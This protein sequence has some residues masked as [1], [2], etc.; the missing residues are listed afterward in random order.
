MTYIGPVYDLGDGTR[1][2]DIDA[3][4]GTCG[5]RL[6]EVIHDPSA[7]WNAGATVC[8]DCG[9]AAPAYHASVTA[10]HVNIQPSKQAPGKCLAVCR[11]GRLSMITTREHAQQWADKHLQQAA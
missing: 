10:H 9:T 5:K 11:C 2:H 1:L 4:C 3:G 7:Q 8:V 6:A